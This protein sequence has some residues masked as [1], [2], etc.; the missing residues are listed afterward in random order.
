MSP[1]TVLRCGNVF[2]EPLPNKYGGIHSPVQF[3]EL[4]LAIARTVY[5]DPQTTLYKDIMGT[6]PSAFVTAVTHLPSRC[7]STAVG[8]T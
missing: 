4:Q 5:K 2:T 6:K 8:Y 3:S 1:Q 7:L